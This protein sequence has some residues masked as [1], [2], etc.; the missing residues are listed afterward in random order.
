MTKRD[1]RFL[2]SEAQEA[3]RIR[4]VE[5]VRGGISQTQAARIF[6][7][8]RVSVNGWMKRSSRGGIKAL[9]TGARGRPKSPALP[10]RDAARAVRKITGACPDQLRLPFALWTREAVV[11]L[12]ALSLIHISEPTRLG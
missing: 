1:A 10:G 7:V 4:V 5:A 3:L 8:S 11:Q 6:G 12:L 9:R 2:T